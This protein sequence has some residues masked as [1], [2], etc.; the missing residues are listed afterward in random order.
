MVIISTS[1]AFA[2]VA[3]ALWLGFVVTT[4]VMVFSLIAHPAYIL[5]GFVGMALLA[6]SVIQE[7]QGITDDLHDW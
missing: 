1:H 7:I 4:K 5:I 6:G 3:S 2:V